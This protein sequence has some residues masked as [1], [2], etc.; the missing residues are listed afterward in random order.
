MPYVN[1]AGKWA[2]PV[3]GQLWRTG[4]D[5]RDK[6]ENILRAI[7][8]NVD[9]HEYAGPGTWNDMCMLSTGLYG[10]GGRASTKGG[11]TGCSDIEYQSQMSI[12]CMMAS[13]LTASS[14]LRNM[15]EATRRILL[16]REMI[17]VDQD[18]LGKQAI[19]KIHNETWNV[20]VKEMSN[21]DHAVAI[22][23]LGDATQ[24]FSI[25]FQEI[26]L[27]GKYEIRDLWEHK[28]IS[29]SKKWKGQ[30]LSHET[31]VFR[32]KKI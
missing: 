13:P 27:P 6:W 21:G 30:V 14:D 3:G 8:I 2:A 22:L 9:L 24:N 29:K 15:T 1:P 10:K 25:E 20:F 5:A 7:N 18:V 11:A 12:W 17:S 19:R 16:N 28:V 32:L 23:N 26:G 4:P 31:K